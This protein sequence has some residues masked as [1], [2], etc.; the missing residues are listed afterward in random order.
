MSQYTKLAVA[1]ISL[2]FSPAVFAGEKPKSLGD[3]P[4]YKILGD[5]P[6]MQVGRIKP[7][8]TVAR[9]VVKLVYGR[10]TLKLLGPD[11]KVAETWQPTAA[12]LDWS[13]RS[14]YWD[15]QAFLRI[16]SIELKHRLLQEPTR[17]RLRTLLGQ[18][19]S[20]SDK[21][22]I[23]KILA[24]KVIAEDP[25]AS[26]SNDKTLSKKVR[27]ALAEL[28]IKFSAEFSWV[29]PADVEGAKLV[30]DGQTIDFDGW[31]RELAKRARRASESADGTANF[32]KIEKKARELNDRFTYYR[33]VRDHIVGSDLVLLITPHPFDETYLKYLGS[34]MEGMISGKLSEGSLTRMQEDSLRLLQTYL[35]NIKDDQRKVPG[36]NPAF[37][38][39]LAR[40]IKEDCEWIPLPIMLSSE[41]GELEQAGF[42]SSKLGELRA[43]FKAVEQ[44][45]EEH[46]GMLDS[47][48]AE[49]L[50][51]AARELGSSVNASGYPSET[52][53][54][55]ESHYNTFGPFFKAP[56]FYFAGFLALL[57][58]VLYK[59]SSA[60]SS[61]FS[62]LLY[63][64]G[65]I[66]YVGGLGL[67]VYGFAL[68]VF[69]SGWAPV[70]NMYET[71]IWVSFVVA[72]LGL[73]FELV[74]RK[75]YSALAGSFAA[76]VGTL[77][78]ANTSLDPGIRSLQPVLRSN[79][80]L[81]IHVLTE[82]SSYAAFALAWALGLF[83]TACY[84]VAT[85]RR[86]VG[87]RELARPLALG[88]P[89]L[90]FGLAWYFSTVGGQT[91][92]TAATT[93]ST[94]A[95]L[96]SLALICL[97]GVLSG[98]A[99]ISMGGEMLSRMLYNPQRWSAVV[100]AQSADQ[101]REPAPTPVG[102]KLS[103]VL[104][105]AAVPAVP[106]DPREAS[107]QASAEAIKPLANFVYRAM[108]VGVLLITAGTFLGGVWADYSWGRF[109]GWDPKEVWALITLL[110]YIIPLHGR[111]AGWINTFG[112]VMASLVCFLSVVMAWYG[113][114]AVLGVGLHAYG[115][116]EEQG[117]GSVGAACLGFLTFGAAAWWRRL[118]ARRPG[119]LSSEAVANEQFA[120]VEEEASLLA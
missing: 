71:V 120:K 2:A 72:L 85:Y 14:L 46:P 115:F 30:V 114:N 32:S 100:A 83:A 112:L 113:V 29:S 7:L 73:C 116:I 82:V 23:E 25:L 51:K 31:M 9:E 118:L 21:A 61:K 117:Q 81:S 54:K 16:E 90:A 11:G 13:V 77:L 63:L 5:L 12:F 76:M 110:I 44:S 92:D 65:M 15:D 89:A 58:S 41:T 68:R 36:T 57:A 74:Y 69:I 38:R 93:A 102:R 8:D 97:G 55:L 39:E 43:A 10:E 87:Y 34:A 49:R 96:P 1:L 86:D 91:S 62:S 98:V 37:D 111:F 45:E 99:V 27:D 80:W 95:A 108:Q 35:K 3:A 20:S 28:S 60:K 24:D 53:I 109:W 104:A 67:E 48:S 59:P 42:S 106:K 50:V 33:I 75:R 70:T 22:A 94:L 78:A 107:M 40:W 88:L 6:V 79:L 47:A 105:K 64:A 26:A 101:H 18:S 52:R 56:G 66:G 84:L 17:T 103:A 119:P 4:S 19:A